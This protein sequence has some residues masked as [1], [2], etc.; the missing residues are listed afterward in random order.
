MLLR[1]LIK[2]LEFRSFFQS[3]C[4][5]GYCIFPLTIVSLITLL[6]NYFIVDLILVIIGFAWSVYGNNYNSN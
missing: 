4:I 6:T 1:Y 2:I 3:I 5:L